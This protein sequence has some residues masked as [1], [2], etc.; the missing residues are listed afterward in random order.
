VAFR[1]PAPG[2]GGPLF[3][4]LL[5]NVKSKFPTIRYWIDAEDNVVRVNDEWESF[6]AENDGGPV[7][8]AVG[9]L[10]Q[11]LW[12][13]I[14]DASLRTLYREMVILA[15][16]GQPV[17]FSFRCDAPRWRRV[18]RMRLTGEKTGVVEFAS[19]LESEEARE[20]VSLLDCRQP[21]DERYVRMCSWCQLVEV[22]GL[23]V[24]VEAAVVELGLMAAPS[25]PAITHTLCDG[26]NRRVMSQISALES[27]AQ[28]QR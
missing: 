6:A 5:R 23:W 15:R 22:H 1:F 16:N 25:L 13:F 10:G 7:G 28:G 4:T 26:C 2:T 14:R 9:I 20:A 19:T 18:F 11:P 3:R 27:G 21:R 17:D 24:P 8:P 12:T